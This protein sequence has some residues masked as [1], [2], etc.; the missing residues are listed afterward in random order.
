MKVFADNHTNIRGHTAHF[1]QDSRVFQEH[2]INIPA[3]FF[4]VKC[5]RFFIFIEPK[6][7]KIYQRLPK[8]AE[9]FQRS[10]KI[11][12]DF[13]RLPKISRWLLKITEGVER[14]STTSKQGKRFPKELQPILCTTEFRR[15][16][17]D[18]LNIKKIEFLFKRFLS[19]YNRYCQ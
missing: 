1:L 9:D 10:L 4:S 5:M 7:P 17:N 14:F 16:S 8:I 2:S 3:N 18:F 15:C 12:E 13:R 11:S 6:F 19:N